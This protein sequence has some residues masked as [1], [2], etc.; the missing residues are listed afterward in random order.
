MPDDQKPE[1]QWKQLNRYM[2]IGLIFP[3]SIVVGLAAG[4][5]VDHLTGKH[6]FYIIGLLLGIA[7]GFVQL[8]R[9]TS[10]PK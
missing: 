1:G 3:T 6:F 4:Y 7:A 2:E 9:I 10:R 5:G 8:I